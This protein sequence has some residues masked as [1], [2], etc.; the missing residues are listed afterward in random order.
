[1]CPP[2]RL[3]VTK[4]TAPDGATA[5]ASIANQPDR[6]SKA[7]RLADLTREIAAQ[8]AAAAAKQAERGKR[9][10][11]ERVLALVDGGSFR[12]LDPFVRHRAAQFGMERSRPF[13]GE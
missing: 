8:H 4:A 6:P 5:R 3:W 2:C 1:M 11:R 9:G 12:E 13:R 7:A 10:A